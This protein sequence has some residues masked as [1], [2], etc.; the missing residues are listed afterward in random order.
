MY[1][2]LLFEKLIP[3]AVYH[4]YQ[5]T[6]YRWRRPYIIF[7]NKDVDYNNLTPLFSMEIRN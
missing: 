7:I 4:E 1:D 5:K 2:I 6:G 3:P